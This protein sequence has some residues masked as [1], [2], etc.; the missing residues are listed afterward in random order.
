M[1]MQGPFSREMNEALY[2]HFGTTLMITKESGDVGAVDEKVQAALQMGIEVIVIGRP[3]IEYGTSFSTVDSVSGGG[4][5]TVDMNFAT[6][7]QPVTTQ[8]A[9]N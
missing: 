6:E 1:A 7:F 2:R 4:Q 8:P 5:T 3:K 9:G